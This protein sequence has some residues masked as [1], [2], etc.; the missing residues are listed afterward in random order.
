MQTP[1]FESPDDKGIHLRISYTW[2]MWS[3]CV[4]ARKCAGHAET[5]ASREAIFTYDRAVIHPKIK[6]MLAHWRRDPGQIPPYIRLC[7]NGSLNPDDV[8]VTA[9]L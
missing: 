6:Q 3:K 4:K 7:A 9:W 8:E 5:S 1:V 2:R